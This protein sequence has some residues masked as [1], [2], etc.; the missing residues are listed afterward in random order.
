MNVP[1]NADRDDGKTECQPVLAFLV[2]TYKTPL[3][4]ADLFSV[5]SAS[6]KFAGCSFALLLQAEDPNLLAYKTI[7][8]NFRERGLT[9]GYFVFDGTPYAGMINRVAPIINADCLCV[10]D[11]THLPMPNGASTMLETV[12]KWFAMSLQQMRVG[13]FTNDGL[14]PLVTKKF[15]DRLGYLF[16]PLCYGRSEAEHWLLKLSSEIGTLSEIADCKIIESSA[17]GVEILGAS[18]ENDAAWATETLEQTL[19]DETVRLSEYVVH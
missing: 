4:T 15:V 10:I 19:A 6:G 14:Y 7:V 3:L 11:S 1:P 12:S 5:A 9:C 18:D 2:P 8:E 17:D 13:M 16:H